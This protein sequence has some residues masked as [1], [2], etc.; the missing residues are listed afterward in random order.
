MSP[1]DLHLV[2]ESATDMRRLR[3]AEHAQ[4]VAIKTVIER[5]STLPQLRDLQEEDFTMPLLGRALRAVREIARVGGVVDFFNV[6]AAAGFGETEK[7]RFSEVLS[8][9]YREEQLGAHVAVIKA[10]SW[11]QRLAVRL[12]S[13]RSAALN[14]DD[15]DTLTAVIADLSRHC[16]RQGAEPVDIWSEGVTAELPRYQVPGL[17]RRRGLHMFWGDPFA[18]KTW[19]LLCGAIEMLTPEAG[20]SLWGHPGLVVSERWK[21]VLWI[22][23][24][25]D[26]GTLRAM[27]EMVCRGRGIARAG[28]ELFHLFAADPRK[29]ITIDALPDIMEAHGPFDAVILDPL[30]ALLPDDGTKWDLDNTGVNRVCLRLRGLANEHNAAIIIAHHTGRDRADYRGPQTWLSSVDVMAGIIAEEGGDAIVIKPQKARGMKAPRPFRLTRSWG[31][32]GFRLAYQ[33]TAQP[34]DDEVIAG[35]GVSFHY[36][37]AVEALRAELGV[38]KAAAEKRATRALKRLTKQKALTFEDGEYGKPVTDTLRTD[39]RTC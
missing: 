15:D 18:G 28:G 6:C 27:G 2:E 7:I 23:S 10:Y 21:R 13:A 33:G 29:P 1:R 22:S 11:R 34:S 4:R 26:A 32:D 38:T 12:L 39:L 17:F 3:H 37:D 20:G 35:L 25:E 14:G 9:T 36:K 5:P 19:C 8:E 24:E 30:V 16:P 31:P